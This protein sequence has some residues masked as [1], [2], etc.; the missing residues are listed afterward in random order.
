LRRRRLACGPQPD[1][2]N[3]SRHR[4]KGERQHHDRPLPRA[5]LRRHGLA[6]TKRAEGYGGGA[7]RRGARD[8]ATLVR[9]VDEY[10]R[11]DSKEPPAADLD[12]AAERFREAGGIR[13]P[14][15]TIE[16]SVSPPGSQ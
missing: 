16:R 13:S 2:R 7:G 6:G 14:L 12:A 1:T 10:H 4:G 11:F 15:T 5:I 9:D 8:T 3:G